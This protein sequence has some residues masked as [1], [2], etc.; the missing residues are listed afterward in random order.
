LIR[1][2]ESVGNAERRL[3]GRDDFPLSERGRIQAQQLAAA[4]GN[5]MRVSALYSS[6]LLRT[7]QTA[8]AI[9]EVTGLQLQLVP[10][11]QEYDF[12]E[13]TGMTW[14]EIAERYPAL[15]AQ[16]RSRTAAYPAYPGEEGRDAFKERVCRALQTICSNYPA[17]STVAAVTHAGP[18]VLAC[19]E[20]LGL[21]YQRPAPFAV[22]NCSIT[23]LD[24]R[25]DRIDLISTN[26]TCHLHE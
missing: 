8:E 10:D 15:V 17:A 2:A 14:A 7:C 13:V 20:A 6:P 1:H 21:P 4:M 25:I 5:G 16:V 22:A 3:Q 9:A 11:L 18:I 24:I 23:T 19:L 26:D 12:G